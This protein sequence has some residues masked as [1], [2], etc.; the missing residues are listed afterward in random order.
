MGYE[1]QDF[2]QYME[3]SSITAIKS[4]VSANLGYSI[5]SKETVKN[6]INSGKIKIVSIKKLKIFREFNFVYLRDSDEEFIKSFMSFCFKK[7]LYL[8]A[9]DI[10]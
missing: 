4:L 5:I 3:L 8:L 10:N 7:R 6:E 2:K 9:F 1:L